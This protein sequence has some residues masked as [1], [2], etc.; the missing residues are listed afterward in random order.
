MIFSLREYPAVCEGEL[1]AR[2]CK[3]EKPAGKY[4]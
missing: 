4:E 2:I 3:A 1:L